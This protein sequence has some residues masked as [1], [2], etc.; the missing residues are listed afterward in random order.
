MINSTK[1]KFMQIYTNFFSLDYYVASFI[2]D[3]NS[4]PMEEVFPS[5]DNI[6]DR[7]L[8]SSPKHFNKS[9]NI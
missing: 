1:K 2:R 3:R 7:T 6:V 4:K 9:F 5:E 8:D